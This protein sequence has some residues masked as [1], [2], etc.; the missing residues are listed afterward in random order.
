[1]PIPFESVRHHLRAGSAVDAD[2]DGV[3]FAAG[4][5][6]VG[7]KDLEHVEFCI[8]RREEAVVSGKL[9]GMREMKGCITVAIIFDSRPRDKRFQEF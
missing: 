5:V 8:Y 3:L 2:Q 1:M 9:D 4:D 7:R 6:E